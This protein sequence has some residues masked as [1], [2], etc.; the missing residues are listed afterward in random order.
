MTKPITIEYSSDEPETTGSQ[1]QRH[2]RLSCAR[3][4][5]RQAELL[6]L[7][8]TVIKI[9]KVFWIIKLVV[10]NTQIMIRIIRD[11]QKP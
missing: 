9:D 8:V 4:V 1:C 3:T 6:E 10:N 5:K 2:M 11:T 7:R